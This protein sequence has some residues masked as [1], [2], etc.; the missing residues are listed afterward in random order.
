M[1][2]LRLFSHILQVWRDDGL[3][4]DVPMF[5]TELNIA[6]NSGEVV[7]RYLR[8]AMAGGFHRLVPDC[9]RRRPLLLPLSSRARSHGGC[10]ESMGT[11]GM[12][13]VDTNYQITQPTSQYFASQLIN[14]RVGATRKRKA[15]AVSA[16]GRY[17]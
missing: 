16:G 2:S 12:F 15:S 13:T 6:W 17:R 14:L 9:G 4:P 7:R 11:F 8:C 3:P 1:T 5:I 10:N